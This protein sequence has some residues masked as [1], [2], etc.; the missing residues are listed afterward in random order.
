MMAE[1][2]AVVESSANVDTNPRT[3][4][5]CITCDGGLARFYLDYFDRINDFDG[6]FKGWE[7]FAR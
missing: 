2:F 4:Q 3:E 6:R 5:T 1:T 7:P